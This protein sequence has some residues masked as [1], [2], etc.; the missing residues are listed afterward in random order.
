LPRRKKPQALRAAADRVQKLFV[1]ENLPSPGLKELRPYLARRKSKCAVP[2][3]GT[4]VLLLPSHTERQKVY[5]SPF[6]QA[7][8]DYGL[9]FDLSSL[10]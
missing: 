10:I 8:P 5:W 9:H 4:K 3:A 6:A 1:Y 7:Q 2:R